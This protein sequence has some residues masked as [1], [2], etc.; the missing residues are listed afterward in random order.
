METVSQGTLTT[1]KGA[2]PAHRGM[3]TPTYVQGGKDPCFGGG[4]SLWVRA[5]ARRGTV[6]SPSSSLRHDAPYHPPPTCS[7]NLP[8]GCL[9]REKSLIPTDEG[10][11]RFR[12]GPGGGGEPRGKEGEEAAEGARAAG[13]AE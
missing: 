4:I 8:E 6:A 5:W 9:G 2:P 10:R 11:G 1:I 7:A 13:G 3:E 12:G